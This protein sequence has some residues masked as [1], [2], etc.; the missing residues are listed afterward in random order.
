LLNLSVA[1][2]TAGLDVVQSLLDLLANVDVILNVLQR[3]IFRKHLE[4]LLNLIL[5]GFHGKAFYRHA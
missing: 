2:D 5:R 3:G 1:D 4:N